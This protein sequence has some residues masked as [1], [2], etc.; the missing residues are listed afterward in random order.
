MGLHYWAVGAESWCPQAR[1]SQGFQF[2]PLGKGLSAGPSSGFG[3]CPE[4]TPSA[5]TGTCP[6]TTGRRQAADCSSEQGQT[7]VHIAVATLR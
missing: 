1:S 5:L 7:Y 4:Q 2:S 6:P 3:F